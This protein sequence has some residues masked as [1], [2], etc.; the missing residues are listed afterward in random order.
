MFESFRKRMERNG[1]DYGE[2]L[3]KQSDIVVEATFNQSVSHRKVMVKWI[4]SGLPHFDEW[5]DELLDAH[6]E[7]K[8]KFNINGDELTYW[9]R[10]RPHAHID[11]PEI[12]VGSYVNIPDSDGNYETWLIVH[13]D[14]DNEQK[15]FQ[16]LKCNYVFQWIHKGKIYKCLGC[17]RYANSYNSGIFVM[18]KTINV[19][20][21]A[22]AYMP[23]NDDTDLIEYDQ[24]FMIT[25]GN[26]DVPIC[27][28][29]SKIILTNPIGVSRFSLAQDQYDPEH[30]NKEL[31]ICNYYDFAI[32]PESAYEHS[33]LPEFHITG[34][35]GYKNIKAG[36]SGRIF[37][38][39]IPDTE[40]CDI[41]WTLVDGDNVYTT[42]S[43]ENSTTTYGDYTVITTDR[44]AKIKVKQ[45]YDLVGR[46]LVLK[47]KCSD[48]RFSS[49]EIEVTA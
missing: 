34:V 8:S 36:G 12:R 7:Q 40:E 48:G 10:F 16:I 47:A 28:R 25:N 3:R 32:E 43:Y 44:T 49:I 42:G 45:N 24:R 33:P 23:T 6:I 19:E 46:I 31:R 21:I 27:F 18:E 29:I 37:S 17:E 39:D 30:D 4:N 38:V 5:R 1:L 14:D 26:R 2:V 20:N 11:H 9:L 35:N 13:V 15:W 22:G 41:M